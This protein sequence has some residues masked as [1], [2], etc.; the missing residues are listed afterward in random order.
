MFW[1]ADD[2]DILKNKW[3][4]TLFGRFVLNTRFLRC[5]QK[6]I[7]DFSNKNSKKEIIIRFRYST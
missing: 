2:V 1:G 7:K 4:R 6:V 3:L 5:C